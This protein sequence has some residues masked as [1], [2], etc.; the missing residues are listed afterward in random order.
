MMSSPIGLLFL[1]RSDQGLRHL[2]FMDRKSL[3]RVIASHADAPPGAA[4][5][6][7]LLDLKDVVEYLDAYF[8]GMLHQFEIPLDPVGSE[9][10]H[11]VW[12]ALLE[13]PFGETRSYGQIAKA[14]RQPKAS[15]AVGL[16]N[17]QN[18]IAIV[19]PCHRVVGANG[20]LVGYGGGLPRK[21]K[22]LDLEARFVQPVG[23][24]GNLF[25][26]AAAER[27]PSR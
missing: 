10:Q 15:R 24:T 19:I 4:W 2:E 8:N 26:A 20:S 18:P 11:R 6:P 12:K 27:R 14:I 3:K 17:N 1:A 13:I 16:A 5:E 25:V 22:L 23:R 7:S 21:R 9:F